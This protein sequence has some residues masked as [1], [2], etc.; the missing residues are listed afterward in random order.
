MPCRRT[1]VD[2]SPLM[3]ASAYIPGPLPL[4]SRSVSSAEIS[5]V[6]TSKAIWPSV[7]CSISSM[8]L[9]PI[10]DFRGNHHPHPFGFCNQIS[11]QHGEH[12]LKSPSAG[13]GGETS[14]R[15]RREFLFPALD[16][17]RR[18]LA[19]IPQDEGKSELQGR[20]VWLARLAHN[21]EVAG[22]NPA[23]ATSSSSFPAFAGTGNEPDVMASSG[24]RC[25][26]PRGHRRLFASLALWFAR[27]R[28]GIFNF[29]L[30]YRDA[31]AR[32]LSTSGIPRRIFGQAQP[33]RD[34]FNADGVFWIPASAG[35][36]VLF[37]CHGRRMA[38]RAR[39][40]MVHAIGFVILRQ[41]QDEVTS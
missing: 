27:G 12:P 4:A 5:D 35:M 34:R 25:N 21:H 11:I 18:S 39:A 10:C 3:M 40:V 29:L 24:G 9:S 41:A 20:A 33:R 8:A 16:P 6:N 30:C 17:S 36:T 13:G 7:G 26:F 23:P 2:C 37:V 31:G 14:N 1:I 19:A 15:P 22:S 32:Y 38:Q 28:G